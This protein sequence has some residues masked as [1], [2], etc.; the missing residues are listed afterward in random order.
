M[1]D[2]YVTLPS[3][4]SRTEFPNNASNHFKIRL[5][6]PIRLEGGEW[7]VGLVAVSLPDSQVVVLVNADGSCSETN[8]DVLFKSKWIRIEASRNWVGNGNFDCLDLSRVF[9]NVD[10]IGFMKSMVSFFEQRRI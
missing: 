2:F 3:H 6:H 9:S 7:K 5:P 10:G 8:P 4:S 1:S